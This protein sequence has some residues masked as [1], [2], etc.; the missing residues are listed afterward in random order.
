MPTDVSDYYLILQSK[1]PN[2]LAATVERGGRFQA[3]YDKLKKDIDAGVTIE[4][5]VTDARD[6][7]VV[8]KLWLEDE[9]RAQECPITRAVLNRFDAVA[10]DGRQSRLA[11]IQMVKLYF[12]QYD[13][14][15]GVDFLSNYL[16]DHLAN[17]NRVGKLRGSLKSLHDEARKVLKTNS[18][19]EI[20]EEALE[21]EVKLTSLFLEYGIPHEN[22]GRYVE[23]C[24]NQVYLLTIES[25]YVGEENPLFQELLS[26]RN[27]LRTHTRSLGI[28]K[29]KKLGEAVIEA[30]ISGCIAE[31]AVMPENWMRYVLSMTHDPRIPESGT[32]E[33]RLPWNNIEPE[34]K[35]AFIG[36]LSGVDLKL[37]LEALETWAK[38]S[39]SSDTA[40]MYP[41]RGRFLQGLYDQ[42]L[43]THSRLFLGLDASKFLAELHEKNEIPVEYATL[44]EH[45]R[46]II[47]VRVGDNH[48]VEGSHNF[49]IRLYGDFDFPHDV[50][51]YSKRTYRS[52]ELGVELCRKAIAAE[53]QVTERSHHRTLTWVR[54]LLKVFANRGLSINP[55]TVLSD[56]DYRLYKSRF[57]LPITQ[58]IAN[59]DIT[60]DVQSCGGRVFPAKPGGLC[61][62]HR[63]KKERISKW[64][65]AS[66]SLRSLQR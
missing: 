59:V 60:C 35:Q 62:F 9:S 24:Q 61:G 66:I 8:I 53:V 15:A 43:I 20:A 57:G 56:K 31:S 52:R 51:N 47:Y 41:Q 14:F 34:Y 28:R 44:R 26:D 40:R 37:F 16:R 5:F 19:E 50:L 2:H 29:G 23:L 21:T 18:H 65:P 32:N 4:D 63:L 39:G 58:P 30:L 17:L 38:R 3:R 22:G 25:L 42:R 33:G 27:Y 11:I 12:E 6:I 54:D 7:R 45:D 46:A 36:W 10:R 55:E 13:D 1:L 64:P 49:S 48:I